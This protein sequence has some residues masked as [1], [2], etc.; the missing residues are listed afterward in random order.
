MSGCLLLSKHPVFIIEGMS[1]RYFTLAEANE[2]LLEI[3]P[4]MGDLLERRARAVV[5][6]Q[7]IEHLLGHNHLDFGG[8]IPTELAQEFDAIEELLAQIRSYGC[9]VKNL[10]AGLIDFLASLNGRDV[11]LCWR[12]GEERIAYYHELHTGFQGRIALE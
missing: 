9:V 3:R 2:A 10:E 12:Y 1:V 5:T 4:I 8:R 6:S 7:E 11:Y